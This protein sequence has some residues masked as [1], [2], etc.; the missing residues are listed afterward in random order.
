[1]SKRLGH[2]GHRGHAG[3]VGPRAAARQPAR[4]QPA[5]GARQACGRSLL[6]ETAN[7]QSGART[8]LY[9]TTAVLPGRAT[10]PCY[11]TTHGLAGGRLPRTGPHR[12]ESSRQVFDAQQS[13]C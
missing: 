8:D 2:Q 12:A 9:L 6:T 10:G 3:Q 1:M 11:S 7:R 5:A 4:W 13:G